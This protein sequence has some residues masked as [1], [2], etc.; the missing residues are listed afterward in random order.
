MALA[1]ISLQHPAI[2]LTGAAAVVAAL[3]IGLE[4]LARRRAS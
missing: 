4:G 3:L 2:A 1:L